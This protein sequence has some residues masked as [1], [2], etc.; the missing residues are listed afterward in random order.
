MRA[1]QHDPRFASRDPPQ[2][3]CC[4]CV[5]SLTWT[6]HPVRVTIR[7]TIMFRSG[8]HEI[9]SIALLLGGG[10]LLKHLLGSQ[11]L[12]RENSP[13]YFIPDVE[14]TQQKPAGCETARSVKKSGLECLLGVRFRG[15]N[16]FARNRGPSICPQPKKHL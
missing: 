14:P 12:L 1:Y 15:Q 3:L 2:S 8:S 9:L 11:S 13:Q 7:D 4:Q 5:T 10:V 16:G 6:P